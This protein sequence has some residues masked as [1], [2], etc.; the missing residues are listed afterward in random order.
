M[1]MNHSPLESYR[2]QFL[3]YKNLGER[4]LS[5]LHPED[6]L[7]RPNEESNSIAVIVHHL[8]GNMLSRWT[9]FLNSDGEKVW[10]NRDTEF[11]E[12]KTPAA[13]VMDWWNEGWG[14]LIQAL[15]ALGDEDLMRT[16]FIR[17]ES[18]T[19]T[20]AIVR[21][22]GHYASHVGQIIYIGKVIRNSDWKT[23]SIPRG[24]SATFNASM[25]KK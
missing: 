21:Q 17:N 23:L 24:G 4:T 5:Q 3:L 13:L 11:I 22:I 9:D 1:S 10:R 12:E 20:D 25:D 7:W 2:K 14:C 19:V 15:D 16:V 6:L 18:M 8:R